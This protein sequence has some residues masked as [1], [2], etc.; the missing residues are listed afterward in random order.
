MRIDGEKVYMVGEDD[1]KVIFDLAVN[2]LNFGSGFWDQPEVDTARR[3]AVLLG[4]DPFK[5]ATPS[6]MKPNYPH[7]FV[8]HYVDRPDLCGECMK[9]KDWMN[10]AE[11]D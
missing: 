11:E 10:H 5:V 8:T 9:P 6:E 1:L 4:L 2:S 7:A 3:L